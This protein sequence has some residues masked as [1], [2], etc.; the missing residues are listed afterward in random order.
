VLIF[1]DGVQR[2]SQTLERPIRQ[3]YDDHDSLMR[4]QVVDRL[5]RTL[6]I[7]VEV[8][9][10][11]QVRQTVVVEERKFREVDAGFASL[12]IFTLRRRP[13]FNGNLFLV[14]ARKL[15]S[16]LLIFVITRII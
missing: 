2:H 6:V 12:S 15:R 5:E 4:F 9:H 1:E 11:R 8:L 3:V 14:R 16:F 13:G 7:N 10:P